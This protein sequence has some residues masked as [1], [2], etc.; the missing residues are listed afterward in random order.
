MMISIFLV[1]AMLPAFGG[2]LRAPFDVRAF[3]A[4][5]DGKTKDTVAFQKALD[6]AA[7]A[8]GGEVAV[9]AGEYLIGSIELKSNT[10]LRLG[11]GAHLLGSP[12]L[13][14]Y[15]IVKVRW[16]GRWID[17]H[18]GLLY[19]KDAR[20]IAV[21]GPGK[22][23]GNLSLGGRT[24]PRRPAVIEPID[25]TDIRLE[26][27]SLDQRSMWAIHPTY[28][29]N[30]VARKLTIR[31]TGGNGDGIDI[32]SCKHVRIEDCDIDAGDDAIAIK[33]GRGM[34]GL[35]AARPTED[36][37]ISN[38]TLG[39]SNFA[40][41][42]IGSETS[43]GIRNVRIEHVKFTHVKTYA[44]YIKTRVGR[45]AFIE[46]ISAKDLEADVAPAGF[47]RLNLLDSGIQDPE[48]VQGDAGIPRV[49]NLSFTQIRTHCGTLVEAAAVSP[50]R[51][52]Q[53]FSLTNV[54]G[55]CS[56][57]LTLANIKGA[58]VGNIKVTGISHPMLKA[59]NVQGNGLNELQ[60]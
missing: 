23:S 1:L 35:L 40:G 20:H 55:N 8:G 15:P 10:T 26:E 48:P 53:G 2:P 43:G 46:N 60:R 51:P 5:G 31:T 50:I 14:D 21:L 18:R 37:L 9:P 3:G 54:T 19:A 17:G 22:I 28:C 34:E 32:D 36:V 24:M 13:A 16:E 52:V 56:A 12:D 6:Q 47:L 44:I 58:R 25:S 4:A 30:F 27:F 42:G 45:G 59:T 49:S 11:E 7:A 41:I 33:S 38:C 29:E 57:G 39:D